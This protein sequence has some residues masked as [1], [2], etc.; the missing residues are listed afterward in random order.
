[1]QRQREA[2]LARLEKLK[3]PV[4]DLTH[5]FPGAAPDALQLHHKNKLTYQARI[6][7]AG[8]VEHLHS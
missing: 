2:L 8:A 6:L 1:L 7:T 4:P 5:P 3:R